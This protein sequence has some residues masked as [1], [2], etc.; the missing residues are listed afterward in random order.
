MPAKPQKKLC[1]EKLQTAPS[2]RPPTVL[3]KL[4]THA[5]AS[6]SPA[7]ESWLCFLS[8]PHLPSKKQGIILHLAF[9]LKQEPRSALP[10]RTTRD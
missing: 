6:V 8:S 4:A 10:V 7:L 5:Y 1:E 9:I 2:P 3:R